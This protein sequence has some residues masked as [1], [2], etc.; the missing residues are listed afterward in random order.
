M[1]LVEAFDFFFFLG[2]RLL[3]LGPPTRG[4]A[5]LGCADDEVTVCCFAFFPDVTSKFGLEGV[6]AG[7]SD[8]IGKGIFGTLTV[9]DGVDAPI[10]KSARGTFVFGSAGL[11]SDLSWSGL[12]EALISGS[13]DSGLGAAL[14]GVLE[15]LWT[16]GVS[17]LGS[18]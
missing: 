1:P 17:S 3:F 2:R 7:G 18:C 8:R 4:E 6:G 5:T 16:T 9:V 13:I 12:N 10:G 11:P 15:S 14:P